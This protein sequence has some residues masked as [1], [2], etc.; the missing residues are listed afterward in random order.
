MSISAHEHNVYIWAWRFNLF[1][2]CP[3]CACP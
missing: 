2:V 1:F 3:Q